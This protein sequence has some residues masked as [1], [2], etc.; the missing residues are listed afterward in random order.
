MKVYTVIDLEMCKSYSK[1]YSYS[2]ETIQIGAV[3]L[4]ENFEIIDKLNIF[5][6]PEYGHVDSF[7]EKLTGITD[8]DL[9]TSISFNE[10]VEKLFNWIGS[11]ENT[12]VSWSRSD[13][14]Q[15]NREAKAKNIKI[16][17]IDRILNDWL[18]C[19]K[20]YGVKL[21]TKRSYSLHEAIIATDI[22]ALDNEHD[23]L[24]DAYNTAL[25]FKKVM[26]EEKLKLNEVYE[27][28]KSEERE[29]LTSPL[30]DLFKGLKLIFD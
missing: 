3:K 15:I 13:A 21:N 18:D 11:D 24:A 2:Q 19:Q 23:G 9:K 4:D 17:N 16:E 28:A 5:V 20:M 12:F 10:A 1:S 26:T 30:G 8:Y 22:K 29:T 7:I 6:K 14:Q 25:I 27:K